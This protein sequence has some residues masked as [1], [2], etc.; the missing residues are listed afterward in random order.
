MKFVVT[1]LLPAVALL[2]GASVLPADSYA[3]SASLTSNIVQK[4]GG[5]V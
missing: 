1:A 4:D 2:F 5:G 3:G